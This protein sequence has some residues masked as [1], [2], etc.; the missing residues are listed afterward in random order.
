MSE[1]YCPKCDTVF[2]NGQ[3]F[4]PDC[5]SEMQ[6]HTTSEMYCPDCKNM[7]YN[8]QK[9]CPDCGAV[10]NKP[11]AVEKAAFEKKID[12]SMEEETKYEQKNGKIEIWHIVTAV[13]V[14]VS[15]ILTALSAKSAGF[16]PLIINLLCA[17]HILFPAVMV[18]RALK[19]AVQSNPTI[20]NVVRIGAAVVAVL[21]DTIHF[22]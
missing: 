11:S 6:T 2:Y 22:I 9:N 5:G 3:R 7:F 16:I 1:R 20:A 13:A 15:G 18:K 12:S 14:A 19:D 8:G 21:V 10:M 17:L 4:C